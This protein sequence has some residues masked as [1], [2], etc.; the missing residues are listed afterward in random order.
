MSIVNEHLALATIIVWPIIPLMWIPVHVFT[1]LFRNLGKKTYII[2][3]CGW[4]A[5]AALLFANK[6]TLLSSIANLPLGFAAV[7]MALVAGGTTLH[8]WTARLLTLTGITG[9]HQLA[10]RHDVFQPHGAFAIVRHP[11]Y[12]AHTLLLLGIFLITR[13]TAVGIV[14]LLDFV[15]AYTVIIPL[16][17][18]ELLKRFGGV[19]NEYRRKVPRFFPYIRL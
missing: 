6:D 5:C 2:I 4:L 13:Y 7:G 16:E 10:N 17:E 15:L 19:Y 8:V 3:F 12:L 9:G 1:D 14:A 11:T 18:R